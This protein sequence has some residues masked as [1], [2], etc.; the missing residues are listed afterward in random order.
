MELLVNKANISEPDMRLVHEL[1]NDQA[2]RENSPS[3]RVIAWEEH[4][5]WYRSAL[6]EGRSAIFIV[7][8]CDERIGYVRFDCAIN[9][10][11]VSIA[12]AEHARGKGIGTASLRESIKQYCVD[13]NNCK[14]ILAYVRLENSPSYYAFKKAGFSMQAIVKR[15]NIGMY[16]FVYEC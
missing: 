1:R 7:S 15:N 11:V 3:D 14:H 8:Y 6:E 12:L 4:A 13:N 9:E 10:A 16:K 5:A 2:A